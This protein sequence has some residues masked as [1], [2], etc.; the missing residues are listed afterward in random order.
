MAARFSRGPIGSERRSGRAMRPHRLWGAGG[1]PRGPRGDGV[2]GRLELAAG[3]QPPHACPDGGED[4]CHVLIAWRGC[5][6]KGE[7]ARAGGAEDAVEHER[8]EVNVELEATPE[9]LDHRHRAGLAVP[10]AVRTPGA[11]VESD[12]RTGMNAQ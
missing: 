11:R 6:V 10:D 1:G 9:A 3:E 4:L 7:A 12:Q 5:G 2:V 8:V